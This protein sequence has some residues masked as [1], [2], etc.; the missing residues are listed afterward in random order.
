MKQTNIETLITTLDVV[1]DNALTKLTNVETLITQLD[2]VADASL[3][4]HTNNETLLTAISAD[5]D[6]VQTLLTQLDTVQ[7]NALTKLTNV[8]TLITA[9]NSGLGSI[10]SALTDI[11]GLISDNKDLLTTIDS[12][13]NDIKTAT[14]L[15]ATAVD[16]NSSNAT[17]VRS[18]VYFEGVASETNS[19]NKNNNVQRVVLATDDIPIALVNT[20]LAEIETT[21]NAILAKNTEMETSLDALISAN[22]TDLIA[23]EATLTEIAPRQAV[24]AFYSNS[25]LADDTITSVID[26]DD[27]SFMT[28]CAQQSSANFPLEIHYSINNTSWFK[29]R[30]K[31]I[32]FAAYEGGSWGDVVLEHPMRYVRLQNTSGSTITNLHLS[33]QLS[34]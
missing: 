3:V 13:T 8:E 30:S 22:H 24:S 33:Y 14:E 20:N 4:K 18:D 2:V 31:I 28:I 25:S 1:Q 11:D 23:L 5:G 26:T 9:S 6:A 27:Y 32:T 15:I 7:D 10:D 19:G 29:V 12:D 17:A 16:T 34:N 21:A